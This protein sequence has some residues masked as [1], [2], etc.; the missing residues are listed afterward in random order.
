MLRR[1]ARSSPK[2]RLTLPPG[3]TCTL[4]NVTFIPIGRFAAATRLSIKALRLYDQSEL[5]PAAFIDPQSGYRYYR[6]E[7]LQRANTIRTLRAIDMPL[8]DIAAIF[9][10]D[11]PETTLRLHLVR[12][13]DRRS[14]IDRRTRRLE[15]LLD[16][17]EFFMT[18]TVTIK[19]APGQRIAAYRTTTTHDTVFTAIPAGFA[20]VQRALG[21]AQPTGAPF[22]LFHTFPDAEQ[23]GEISM[24]IPVGSPIAE[25]DS[26]ENH[27]LPP[28]PVAS[29]VHHGSYTTMGATYAAV[30]LW[31]QEHGHTI[32][33][34]SREIY[35]NNPD[36]VA[37]AGL[38][39]E[40]QWPIDDDN[41]A[42]PAA[43]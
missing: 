33:G 16:S 37:E 41:G 28:G 6:P 2:T 1:L 39:T 12:L 27:E 43:E 26:V 5:L 10:G 13:E 9:A 36:D 25:T 20:R 11:D 42:G 35:L 18:D 21:H 4:L 19:T 3:S 40:I 32:T 22:T 8:A 29:I 17:K 23:A 30:G 14:E 38:L 31:I 7:Q 24:C 15:S 34:P